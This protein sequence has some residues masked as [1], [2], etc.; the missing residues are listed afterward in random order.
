[1]VDAD[2]G[3]VLR[4]DRPQRRARKSFEAALKEEKSRSAASDS[5]F[6][7]ALQ[8]QRDQQALLDRKFKEAMKKAAEEPDVK[9]PNPFDGD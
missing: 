6:D 9:P 2:T 7:K 3:V 8:A 1:L 4:D 5:Q